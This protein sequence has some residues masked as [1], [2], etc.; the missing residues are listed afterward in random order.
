MSENS[1][2]LEIWEYGTVNPDRYMKE[3]KKENQKSCPFRQWCCIGRKCALW[4][5]AKR[6]CGLIR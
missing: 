3:D 4:N 5:D 6:R 2:S 1:S